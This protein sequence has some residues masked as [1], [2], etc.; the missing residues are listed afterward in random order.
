LAPHAFRISEKEF[1]FEKKE[2][3][4]CFRWIPVKE[5]KESNFTFVIDKRI[6]E[7]L[8]ET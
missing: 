1:D 3:A 7:L 6:A 8:N 5:I 4:Q 2:G